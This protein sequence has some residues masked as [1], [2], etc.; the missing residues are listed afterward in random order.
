MAAM[1]TAATACVGELEKITPEPAASKG[2]FEIKATIA[3]SDGSTRLLLDESSGKLQWEKH[4]RIGIFTS[5]PGDKGA[6]FAPKDYMTSSTMTFTGEIND[7]Y[8]PGEYLYGVHPYFGGYDYAEGVNDGKLKL[9]LTNGVQPGELWGDVIVGFETY[10]HY[11]PMGGDTFPMVARSKDTNM[12]FYNACGGLTITVDNPDLIGVIITNNDE[13]PLWGIM[14]LSFDEEDKPVMES[15]SIPDEFYAAA[16]ATRGDFKENEIWVMDGGEDNDYHMNPGEPYYVIMPPGTYT[17]GFTVTYRTPSTS[18]TYNIPGPV[19]IERSVFSRI[20]NRDKGLEFKHLEGNVTFENANFKEYCVANF[21]ADGDGEISYAEALEVKG[22]YVT[23]AAEMGRM[24]QELMCFE[25]LEELQWRGQDGAT[26]SDSRLSPWWFRKLKEIDCSYLNL[27]NTVDF[28]HNPDLDFVNLQYNSL[29]GVKLGNN[30]KL[31]TFA[32]TGNMV[33]ELDLS[34]SPDLRLL[35]VGVNQLS[36]L[37]VS[38]NRN[39]STIS[40]GSNQ[41]TSLDV[42]RHINLVSLRCGDNNISSLDVSACWSL[43]FLAC[44][45]NGMTSLTLDNPKLATLYC[46]RNNISELAL[47]KCPRLELVSCFYNNMSSIDLTQLA[48]LQAAFVSYNPIGTLDVSKNTALTD[49]YCC[50]NGLSTLDISNNTALEYFRCFDND[51]QSLDLSKAPELKML[52]AGGNPMTSL[53]VSNNLK[54]EELN[55]VYTELYWND[56]T[57]TSPLQYLYVAEGQSIPGITAD[58][59]DELLP[60]AT[61]IV[62]K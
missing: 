37:N 10:P 11:L 58:R 15:I 61:E 52:W 34:G 56:E 1:L 18:A 19:T 28:T 46:Y 26:G 54:L 20:T 27:Q 33:S 4:D 55:M 3:D 13:T 21:D 23:N 16:G 6:G 24:G 41:L 53:D 22:I 12:K 25:N 14:E 49:L 5:A 59:S 32:I 42:S 50:V 2:T 45:D 31:D 57:Y 17:K 38:A 7:N 9:Y 48:D 8:T 43:S 51:L 62:I 36:K 44:N 30:P 29:S 60:S 39:L 40:A 35:Y 47:D